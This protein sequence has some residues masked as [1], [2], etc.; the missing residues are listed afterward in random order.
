MKSKS[1]NKNL[2]SAKTSKK[3]EFYTQL[4][5]IEKEL[6]HYKAHF[7][8][9]VVLCNCDDPRVSNFFDYF[10]KNFEALGLKKLI[11]TCYKNQDM[12]LF[13]QH[14]K[15]QAIYLEYEG[16]KNGDKVPNPEEIGIK[17]LKGDGDFRSK[18]CIELLK[19]ADIVVTNPPFS[20][21]REYVAQL[22][23]Y[24][25][26]F[27][28]IGHQNAITYKEIFKLIKENK[29]WLGYGFNRNCAHFMNR[30]YE[31]YATDADH[32]EGMIR[33]SGVVWYTNLDIAKRH[34]DLILH[35]K[36]T[37][38]EYPVYDN[39]D[40]I[41]VDK[42]NDI[43][44]DYNGAMG[45]PITFLDKYNPDQF[46]IIGLGNSRENFTPNKDYINPYKVLKDGQ[47]KNGN[48][49]NCVLAIE[50]N[51][52]PNEIHYTS[53]NSRYLIAPYA[54]ILIKNKR[55]K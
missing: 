21:F 31:D 13:S 28:I 55:I 6:S 47:K 3:D 44:K 33:V 20:L 37:P 7:K 9:K 8:D 48:A 45:V 43:P 51:V 18:E 15:E 19:H 40:A 29:I 17:H 32:K 23:E 14:D 22:I 42:T 35:K 39:Y 46:E 34:E 16:D 24:D 38:E 25:K 2:H 36:Y 50:T 54:R 4:A 52:K 1:S 41:N 30:H 53:S 49:I 5:D 12:D 10:S 11:T 26:K 27:V